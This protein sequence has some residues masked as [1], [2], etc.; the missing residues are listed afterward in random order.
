[1]LA[2]VCMISQSVTSW[3]TMLAEVLLLQKNSSRS[4]PALL[5]AAPLQPRNALLVSDLCASTLTSTWLL[6][7]A[8]CWMC[9][10]MICCAAC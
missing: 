5:V 4:E 9:Y 7:R 3:Q 6:C 10:Q 1:M 8:A 2:S